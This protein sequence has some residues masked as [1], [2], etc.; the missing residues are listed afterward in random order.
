M[1]ITLLLAAGFTLAAAVETP[2]LA[3]IS[4]WR[5]AYEDNL[6]APGGWLS[7]SGLFWLHEGANTVGSDPHA[8]V[9]L[10]DGTPLHA[11]VMTMKDG[12]VSFHAEGGPE[13]TLK[14][15]VPGPPDVLSI[16]TLSL[17]V[18]KRGPRTGVRLKDPQAETRRA[19]TGCK[20]FPASPGWKVSARWTAYK[21]PHTVAILNVLGMQSEEPAPGFAEFTLNGRQMRLEPITEDDHLFFLFKDRTS[22]QATYAAGRFLYA[23]LPK[24]GT[25]ELDFNKSENPPC[26]FTAFATCPLPPKQNVLPVAVTAGEK[27][28]GTH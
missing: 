19:F 16:G 11:G 14:P 4:R 26:A 28:Y 17:T 15:D 8:D 18:I 5:A 6:K 27:K 23:D 9:I 22:G 21:E 13:R 2:W 12:L 20:W 7:V 25:V 1:R 24:D 3:E 10:R